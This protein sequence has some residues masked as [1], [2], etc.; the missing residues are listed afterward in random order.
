MRVDGL[1]VTRYQWPLSGGAGN[2]RRT[3][4]TREGL[5]VR[6]HSREG[7]YGYGEASPLPG[8]SPDSLEACEGELQSAARAWQPTTLDL[9]SDPLDALR[10]AVTFARALSPAAVFALESAVLDLLGKA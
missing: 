7:G 5:I 2:A 9:P 4:S 3:W 8:Y 6:V 10:K 1:E